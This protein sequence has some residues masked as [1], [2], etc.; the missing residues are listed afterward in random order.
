[1]R[2]WRPGYALIYGIT[3]R[4]NLAFGEFTTVGAFAALAGILIGAAIPAGVPGLA[5]GGLLLAA[6]DRCSPGRGS[7][8][9]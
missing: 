6:V 5:L 1:M 2:C 4:I 7:V 8:R 9:R 3:G